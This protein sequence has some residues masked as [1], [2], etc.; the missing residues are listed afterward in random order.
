VR[1]RA[2]RAITAVA[3]LLL[4]GALLGACGDDGNEGGP[5]AATAPAET[6]TTGAQGREGYGIPDDGEGGG[7]GDAARAGGASD[8]E[9]V[10]A[11]IEAVL[12]DEDNETVCRDVLTE[13]LVGVA[14]GDLQGCLD[15]RRPVTLADGIR[16]LRDLE[17]DGDTATV[18]VVPDGGI[19]DEVELEV[20]A[21]RA[22]DGWRIDGLR[23]D[24][25]VGP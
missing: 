21:V 19:Y 25:P 18:V 16:R 9:R 3:V 20:T 22:G 15:G 7:D 11:A 8:A 23:A 24:I 6:T 12:V 2:N 17:V 13:D 10:E 5:D 14:Y 4:A 1:S